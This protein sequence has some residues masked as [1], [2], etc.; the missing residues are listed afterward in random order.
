[1]EPLAQA[2]KEGLAAEV[3]VSNFNRDQMLRAGDALGKRGVPLASNQVQYS[4]VRRKNEFNGLLEE[5]A[6]S[7]IR[8]I[9]YSPLGMGLLSGKYGPGKP[10]SGPRRIFYGGQLAR[11][12][13]LVEKL[14]EV[15]AAQGGKTPNQVALNWILSKGGLPIPGAK[16]AVQVRENAGALG[17]SLEP[18]QVAALDEASKGFKG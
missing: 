16:N 17:W 15:G 5:C 13:V 10:P 18:A 14:R 3:G 1:M 2:V 12:Q 8:F 6:S 7:G 9:A 11:I 4:L